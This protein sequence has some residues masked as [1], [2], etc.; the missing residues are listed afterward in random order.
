MTTH[1]LR[2]T[3]DGQT[4]E[5]EHT[6]FTVAELDT[7][8]LM[9]ELIRRLSANRHGTIRFHRG[10]E[11]C[12]MRS[13]LLELDT[14]GRPARFRFNPDN[15]TVCI[16]PCGNVEIRSKSSGKLIVNMTS[17]PIVEWRD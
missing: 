1:F 11:V 4:V 3:K 10:R 12:Q 13:D 15:V 16:S 5:I 2:I 9:D 8:A 7:V 6:V 17:N 14:C